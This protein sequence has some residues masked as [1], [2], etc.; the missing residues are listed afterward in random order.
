[1]QA[2]QANTAALTRDIA[3]AM[4]EANKT[5]E[6]AR[7]EAIGKALASADLQ[8]WGDPAALEKVRDSFTRGQ[9]WASAVQGIGSALPEGFMETIQTLVTGLMSKG[10]NATTAPA[11]ASEPV[12]AQPEEKKE[13]EKETGAPKVAAPVEPAKVEEPAPKPAAPKAGGA[14]GSGETDK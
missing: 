9:S 6:I 5:A 2:Q 1:M 13:P 4:I 14:K 11:A 8:I 7:A 3:L 10:G 12:V